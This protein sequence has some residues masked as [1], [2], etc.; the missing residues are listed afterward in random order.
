MC[1]ALASSN[2]FVGSGAVPPLSS[3][4]SFNHPQYRLAANASMSEGNVDDMI[5]LAAKT[6]LQELGQQPT[7]YPNSGFWYPPSVSG[8]RTH[9]LPPIYQALP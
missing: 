5:I 9:R 7:I 3:S 6:L 2:S 8:V 4:N 1:Y